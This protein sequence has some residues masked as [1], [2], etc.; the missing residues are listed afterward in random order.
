[1]HRRHDYVV[2][3]LRMSDYRDLVDEALHHYQQLGR[4]ETLHLENRGHTDTFSIQF[5]TP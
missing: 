1:M 3:G 5:L 4:I 2:G